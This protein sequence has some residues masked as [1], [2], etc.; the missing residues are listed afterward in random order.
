MQQ[1]IEMQMQ[2]DPEKLKSLIDINSQ[3]RRGPGG[4]GV[5]PRRRPWSHG[6][7]FR[8]KNNEAQ[9]LRSVARGRAG[10]VLGHVERV[11]IGAAAQHRFVGILLHHLV[12]AAIDDLI[13][14]RAGGAIEKRLV[15]NE[16]ARRL[17][18][19]ARAALASVAVTLWL[20]GSSVATAFCAAIGA[21][22][23]VAAG[24]PTGLMLK[25]VL[26]AASWLSSSQIPTPPSR[27]YDRDL[28][29]PR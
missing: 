8:S 21:T 11:E 24:A 6:R 10:C 12:G 15:R 1:T 25:S 5:A 14:D 29:T 23:D 2:P 18:I 7:S 3:Y 28:S 17:Q 20:A 22:T 4:Q 9:A 19:V 27:N 16:V 26:M 13:D